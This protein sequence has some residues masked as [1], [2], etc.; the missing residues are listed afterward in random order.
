MGIEPQVR[1]GDTVKLIRVPKG[2]S[3]SPDLPTESVFRKCLGHEFQVTGIND[4][5]MAELIVESITGS[6]GETIWVEPQY[7]DVVAAK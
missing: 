5:N 7:L 2:L 4:Y 1:I 3:S 6:V